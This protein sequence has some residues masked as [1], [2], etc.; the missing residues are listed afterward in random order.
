M[1]ILG[2]LIS[3]LTGG[4][5]EQ[6]ERAAI[7]LPEHG[8]QGI[9]ALQSLLHSS[10]AGERWWATRTLAGFQDAE[11]GQLLVATLDDADIGVRYCAALSLGKQ[12]HLTAVPTLIGALDS[13]DTLLARLAA[14]ALAATG[15]AA[16]EPLISVLEGGTPTARVEAARTLALIG[17]TRAI[18][19]LFKLLDSDSISLQ[20]WANEGL[21]KMG[22]G[23][24]FFHP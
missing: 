13:G 24:S 5:S 3:D 19:T 9:A 7:E 4:D 11:A 21:D 15:A 23:M 17:D 20:H 6:A 14:D 22:V 2:E 16:V 12:P 1:R 10:D 8:K 18:P